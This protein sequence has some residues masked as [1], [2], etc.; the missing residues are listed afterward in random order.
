MDRQRFR[1]VARVL[2][3]PIAGVYSTHIDSD[4]HFGRHWHDSYGFGFLEYGAQSWWSGRGHVRGYPGDVISTNPGEVHDGQPLGEPTRRWRIVYMDVGV[5]M[6]ITGRQGHHAEITRPVIRDASLLQRLPRLFSLIERWNLYPG[7]RGDRVNALAFEEALTEACVQL[8]ARHGSAPATTPAPA[9]D[10][11]CVRDRLADELADPP[12]L[13]EIAA[14]TGLSRY[15]VLRRFEKAF[16]LP[17]HAWL[18][19]C[20]AE[21]ARLLIRDG[22]SL[23]TTAMECGFVDQS[24]MTRV[25]VRQFG[26]TPGAWRK[27]TTLQ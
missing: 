3:S 8:M 9:H 19:R 11:T 15:Q 10:L 7:K 24:H 22:H 23:A 5:M 26:F 1:H 20:R 17:P 14:M 25:F 4:H 6:N 27:A 18:I 16:G 13:A 21:R 2:A 12:S